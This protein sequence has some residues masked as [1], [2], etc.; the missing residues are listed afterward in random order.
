MRERDQLYD[1]LMGLDDS[2][3]TVKTQILS[4]KP[5]PSLG[6]AYHLVAE[7]EQQKQIS[8]LRKQTT[9]AAAFQIQSTL[10]N[11]DAG[12]RRIERKERPKCGVCQ[13]VGHTEDQCFEVIGYP[14]GWRKSARD[15]RIGPWTK[16]KGPKV[17]QVSMDD[18]PIPGLTQAQYNRLVQYSSHEDNTSKMSNQTPPI[19]N[20]AGKINFGKP[21]IIDS[22]AT[23]AY[24]LQW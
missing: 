23:R 4:T 21:W 22:G 13:K 6:S 12:D 11:K 19:A 10:Y 7:D 5:T 15:K 24:N 16:K 17:A 14:P 20:M 1:F 8:S 9:E 18:S 2:F 3:G